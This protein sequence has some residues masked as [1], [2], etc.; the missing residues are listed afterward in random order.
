MEIDQ[1]MSDLDL[2]ENQARVYLLLL[3]IGKGNIQ[4]IADKSGLKRTTVYSIL[5]TLIQKEL[6]NMVHIGAHRE[7]F[8]ENPRKILT[9]FERDEMDIR[10]RRREI[11]EFMPQLLS[12]Y[13]AHASKPVIRTYEGLEGI[14]AVFDETLML[15][16]GSETLAFASFHMIRGH[17]REWIPGFIARRAKKGI[18]QRCICVESEVAKTELVA[19]DKRDLRVTRLVPGDKFPFP[20][21]QINIFG[22]RIF[23]ASYVDLIAIVIES[24]AI[25]KSMK[26]IFELAWLGAE[27]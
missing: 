26:S 13:N 6:I 16:R 12:L 23:L 3:Q 7:Y 20:V 19:N 10:E 8:A 21:D 1:I 4:A 9:L 5:D 14:K 24:E 25:A 18:T 22:N 15:P 2:N 27:K 11:L 17:L